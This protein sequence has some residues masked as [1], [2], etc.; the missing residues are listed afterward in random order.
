VQTAVVL[1]PP[2]PAFTVLTFDRY[3][4]VFGAVISQDKGGEF[5]KFSFRLFSVKDCQSSKWVRRWCVFQQ[6]RA[7]QKEKPADTY[8]N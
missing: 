1:P 4:G 6:L 8:D 2:S 5:V 3:S 7:Q